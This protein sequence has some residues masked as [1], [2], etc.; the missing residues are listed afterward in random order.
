M[1][2]QKKAIEEKTPKKEEQNGAVFEIKTPVSVDLTG[3]KGFENNTHCHM[4][5]VIDQKK[6]D[7]SFSVRLTA[8]NRVVIVDQDCL[9]AQRDAEPHEEWKKGDAVQ[10]LESNG[11]I[12]GWWDA[13]VIKKSGKKWEVK[14][15]GQYEAHEDVSLVDH[16]KMRRAGKKN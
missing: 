7:G 15:K 1:S 4:D 11:G 6:E 10:V 2:V 8:L 16:K 5:G 12:D 3:L 13:I 14:W 9:E